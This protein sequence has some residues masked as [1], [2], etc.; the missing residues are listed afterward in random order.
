MRLKINLTIPNN[1]LSLP[2][3]YNHILHA[4]ILN[5]IND[6]V[7]SRYIHD[8]GWSYQNRHYKMYTF[9]RLYGKFTIDTEKKVIFYYNNVYLTL[10]SIDDRFLEYVLNNIISKDSVIINA[11]KLEVK[12]VSIE[13]IDIRSKMVIESL[14]PIVAYKTLNI[15]S[16]KKTY[17]FNP[18]EEEFEKSI[19]ENLIRKYIA[20]SGNNNYNGSFSISPLDNYKLKENIVKYKETVIKGWSGKFEISGDESLVKLAFDTGLGSKNSQGFG[21]IRPV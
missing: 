19:K 5:W 21:C 1:Q 16:S 3:H 12:E 7:Y 14:S 15:A 13:K 6:E 11:Q 20:L 9:S 10:C 4:T 18:F 8:I 17:Y 2:I